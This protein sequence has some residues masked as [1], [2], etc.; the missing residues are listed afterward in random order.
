GSA[1]GRPKGVLKP[2]GNPLPKYPLDPIAAI[3]QRL[4]IA[5]G[6]TLSLAG[7]TV[8]AET[9]EEVIK[10]INRYRQWPNLARARQVAWTLRQAELQRLQITEQ[11]ATIFPHLAPY[12]L[13]PNLYLKPAARGLVAEGEE[14]TVGIGDLPPGPC[15]VAA[16][17][18]LDGLSLARQL[19]LAQRYFG[20][21]GLHYPLVLLVKLTGQ[22]GD[23][24]TTRL[25]ELAE[26]LKWLG[27]ARIETDI[28]IWSLA[29]LCESVLVE[30]T[31]RAR[32]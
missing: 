30:L 18:D 3:T 23:R 25:R 11:E 10:L 24:L 1:M 31:H 20:A 9:R 26:S 21:R 7:L 16:I 19:G 5:P 22:S 14:T 15:M 4:L 32:I 12:L 17:D 2:D 6:E 27:E 29:N 13:Y 8:A 28:R